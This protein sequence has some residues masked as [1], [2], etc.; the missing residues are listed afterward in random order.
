MDIDYSKIKPL[1]DIVVVKAKPKTVSKFVAVVSEDEYTSGEVIAVGPG[2][3]TNSGDIVSSNVSVGDTVYFVG[4]PL[5]KEE[6]DDYAY[7]WLVT[8]NIIGIHCEQ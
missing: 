3:V 4:N 7:I 5:K 6:T 8:D 2:R 1:H